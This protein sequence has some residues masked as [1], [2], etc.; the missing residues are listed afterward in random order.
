MKSL[1]N[2]ARNSC[3]LFAL[4]TLFQ[5][6][7]SVNT[8][9]HQQM[10][11]YETDGHYWTVLLVCKQ[12]GIPEAEAIAYAAEYPDNVM[13]QD[14][15]I[16]KSRMTYLLPKSQ[17]KVHALTGG[18]PEEELVISRIML[19]E[20]KSA[21]QKGTAAHRLGDTYAHTNDKK[22]K[23]FPHIIGHLFHMKKPDQIH[24]NPGKY[25]QYVNDLIKSFGGPE[26][27]IDMFVFN[28]ISDHGLDSEKNAAILKTEYN[29]LNGALAFSVEKDHITVVNDY[30]LSRNSL[31]SY[32]I[33]RNTDSKGRDTATIIFIKESDSYVTKYAS[34]NK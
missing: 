7:S 33:H 32:A 5:I 8:L 10:M 27:E 26:A 12:L 4:I 25:L 19:A 13:N 28:Y 11:F 24:R 17:K 15:Y 18:L 29:R 3:S 2:S 22:H 9:A 6:T 30:L 21:R 14:G 23:M 34:R 1:K 16:V 20:A 31:G